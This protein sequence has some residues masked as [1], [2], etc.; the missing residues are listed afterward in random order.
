MDCIRGCNDT[1]LIDVL[2]ILCAIFTFPTYVIKP[3]GLGSIQE[4]G[5]TFLPTYQKGR[6]FPY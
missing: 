1:P 4:I 2:R 5:F 6:S 3:A